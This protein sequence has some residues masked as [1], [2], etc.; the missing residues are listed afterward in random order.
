[1]NF[2]YS[3]RIYCVGGAI[4]SHRGKEKR[5]KGF[6]PFLG[7]LM[8]ML[9][10]TILFDSVTK[11]NKLLLLKAYATRRVGQK[12]IDSHSSVL[13]LEY[14]NCGWSSMS[15]FWLYKKKYSMSVLMDL[16]NGKFI[17]KSNRISQKKIL[18]SSWLTQWNS[19]LDVSSFNMKIYRSAF[20]LNLSCCIAFENI[21]F[22]NFEVR[23]LYS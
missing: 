22:F 9:L 4:S 5:K 20:Q 18:K 11:T 15:I 21:L 19:I 23:I 17:I 16:L 14:W 3:I 7:F 10:S 8:K 13:K 1:M 2:M 12:G 6:I